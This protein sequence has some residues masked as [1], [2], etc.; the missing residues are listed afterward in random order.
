[1]GYLIE[2]GFIIKKILIPEADFQ[3]CGTIPVL[4]LSGKPFMAFQLISVMAY[5][6][7]SAGGYSSLSPYT[8]FSS[9]TGNEA[10]ATHFDNFVADGQP[11]TYNLGVN[12]STDN[13]QRFGNDLLISIRSG[14]DPT[15]TG[16]IEFSVIYKELYF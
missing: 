11:C 6:T 1:M 7:G 5:N 9:I 16:D 13:A 14:V 2:P 4:L 12:V 10:A 15:G 8:I 3:T